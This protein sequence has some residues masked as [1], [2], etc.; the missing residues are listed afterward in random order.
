LYVY[1]A[2]LLDSVEQRRNQATQ[3]QDRLQ[4]QLADLQNSFAKR[5]DIGQ[6]SASRELLRLRYDRLEAVLM[7]LGL[8]TSGMEQGV[9]GIMQSLTQLELQSTWLTEISI[10]QGQL[11]V[12]GQT[13]QPAQVPLLIEQLEAM[14]GLADKRFARLR[15]TADDANGVHEFSLQSMDFVAAEPLSGGR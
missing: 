8:R 3:Q 11:S 9:A 10:F 12:M 2:T 13:R 1:E 14:D 4:N 5:G 15:L 6:L 7:Q